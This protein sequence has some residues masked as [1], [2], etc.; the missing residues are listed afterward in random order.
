MIYASQGHL[1]PPGEGCAGGGRR[2]RGASGRGVQTAGTWAHAAKRTC[3]GCASGPLRGKCGLEPWRLR[4]NGR[5]PRG[6]W[7]T[8][9]CAITSECVPCF[10]GPLT[11][12]R[13]RD[14]FPRQSV[15]LGTGRPLA[16]RAHRTR[17]AH[18]RARC[19]AT[20]ALREFS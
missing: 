3:R 16:P 17:I 6:P 13:R 2:S 9:G 1:G 20:R 18:K 14:V 15:S 8:I 5:S 4:T 19:L 11:R 7:S 12:R 10:D